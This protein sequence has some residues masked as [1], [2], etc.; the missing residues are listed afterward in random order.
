LQIIDETKADLR[1][2]IEQDFGPLDRSANIWDATLNWV[3]YK[4]RQIP[5]R[6]R[7]VVVS[8]ECAKHRTTYPAID[9]IAN[10]LRTGAN[11]MPRL[12]DSI[13]KKKADPKADLMFNDWQIIHFHLGEV[14]VAPDKVKRSGDLLFAY[15]TNDK[16]VLLDVQPHG[17]WAM[18]SLLRILLQTSPQDMERHEIKGIAGL[19]TNYTA[20]QVYELR[21]AGIN[22]PFE[23]EGRFFFSPGLGI[24][25]SGRAIDEL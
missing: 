7:H 24:A 23:L 19:G 18:Q 1:R 22:A 8:G 11:L 17:S 12:S 4:T 5:Q 15:I 21:K 20:D 9:A 10:E 14:F 3:H 13:R 6:P 2:L 16:A 25:T